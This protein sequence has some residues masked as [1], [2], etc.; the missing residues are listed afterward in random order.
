MSHRNLHSQDEVMTGRPQEGL[1]RGP[2][3][4]ELFL[5]EKQGIYLSA[6]CILSISS[7]LHVYPVART[8]CSKAVRLLLGGLA[9]GAGRADRGFVAAEAVHPVLGLDQGA[10]TCDEVLE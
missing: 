9:V 10:Q 5:L 8:A 2:R 3:S 1:V 4:E 6:R 7:K